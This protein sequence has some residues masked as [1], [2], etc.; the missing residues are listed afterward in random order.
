LNKE[1][2]RHIIK[3]NRKIVDFLERRILNELSSPLTTDAS[4]DTSAESKLTSFEQRIEEFLPQLLFER[5]QHL[6]EILLYEKLLNETE[7]DPKE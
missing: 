2:L 6:R 7:S 5:R 3:T 1:Q 4:N